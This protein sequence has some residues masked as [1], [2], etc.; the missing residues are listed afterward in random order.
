MLHQELKRQKE[1]KTQHRAA[2]KYE[3]VW[4][5]TA[6]VMLEALQSFCSFD[7]AVSDLFQIAM[8]A[9][10]VINWCAPP[11]TLVCLPVLLSFCGKQSSPF[12]FFQHYSSVFLSSSL[13]HH[14]V[15]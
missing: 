1:W 7:F 4:E 15:S 6:N 2:V 5:F 14:H 10:D 8:F 13:P 12:S 11:T 9:Q 3:F